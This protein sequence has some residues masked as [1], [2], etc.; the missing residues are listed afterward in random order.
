MGSN[1]IPSGD[2]DV[3]MSD[4]QANT[5]P[6][7][8]QGPVEWNNLPTLG[9]S[10]YASPATLNS[11]AI[12]TPKP[13]PT[14]AVS[15]EN[16]KPLHQVSAQGFGGF[17]DVNKNI[18]ADLAKQFGASGQPISNPF[19]GN[20]GQASRNQ[21]QVS[22][23]G[24]AA[25]NSAGVN[26]FQASAVG[27]GSAEPAGPVAASANGFG[28]PSAPPAGGPFSANAQKGFG[29]SQSNSSTAQMIQNTSNSNQDGS[30]IQSTL[31]LWGSVDHSASN[32]SDAFLGRGFGASVQSAHQGQTAQSNGGWGS[33]PFDATKLAANIDNDIRRLYGGKAA[34]STYET[35]PFGPTVVRSAAVSN[36][37][38][39]RQSG[40]G[41]PV[42]QV[43]QESKK[44]TGLATSRWA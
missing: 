26:P 19:L 13:A 16:M 36:A 27:S 9:A 8:P 3:E 39:S 33:A 15:N 14:T 18:A 12:T 32:G 44:A 23:F 22:G 10:K 1:R 42:Y 5:R 20:G 25:M 40:S 34:G 17:G 7:V 11:K 35:S 30:S 38:G 43:V 4:V 28:A 2:G 24:A 31:P 21:A 37:S 29:A 6:S 41:P